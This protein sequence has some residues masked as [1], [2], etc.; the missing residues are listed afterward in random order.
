MANYARSDFLDRKTRSPVGLGAALAINGALIGALLFINP[1]VVKEL[2]TVFDTIRIAPEPVP[3]TPPEPP[4]ERVAEQ[5]STPSVIT[6]AT[7]PVADADPDFTARFPP[8][9]PPP[10]PGT[11]KIGT[12]AVVADP[13]KPPSVFVGP[14]I[15]QRFAAALQP[16]YPPGKIRA[17]E[18][19]KV[20]V[21]VLIGPDGRV[22][23]VEKVEGDETFFRATATQATKRW[24]FKPA[25]RDGVPVEGWRTMTVRFE[26]DQ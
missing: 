26:L 20:V 2:P 19:G 21:R 4:R 24:R 15:D 3:P 13:P 16:P 6:P 17:E 22:I 8:L 14:Q 23:R 12:G 10:V 11:G 25:T 5:R 7:P 9:G 18:E 1:Q